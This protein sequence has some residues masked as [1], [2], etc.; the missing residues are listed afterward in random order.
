M[1]CTDSKS[2]CDNQVN[3]LFKLFDIFELFEIFV[4][5]C[6]FVYCIVVFCCAVL[7]R[8]ALYCLVC[9]IVL[10]NVLCC[11]RL[12]Y[13]DDDWS[14]APFSLKLSHTLLLVPLHTLPLFLSYQTSNSTRDDGGYERNTKIN[15]GVHG[16]K[17]YHH[18]AKSSFITTTISIKNLIKRKQF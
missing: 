18:D 2:C 8:V 13:G 9:C 12:Q 6:V 3:Q 11:I 14:L 16:Q 15:D 4:F 10:S 1:R 5:D 7:C 17:C